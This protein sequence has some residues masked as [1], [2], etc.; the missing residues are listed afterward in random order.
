MITVNNEDD[1][2]SIFNAWIEIPEARKSETSDHF[3]LGLEGNV[4]PS[5]ST[6]FQAYYKTLEGLMLYNQDKIDIYDPDY[7][8]GSGKAHGFEALIRYGTDF[9]DLYAAYTLGWT[10]VTANGTTYSPRYDRRHTVNLLSVIHAAA[11]VD[12][13]LRWSMGSGLPFTETVGFYDRLHLTNA[14]RGSYLGETGTPYVM[15]GARNA[16]RL[17]MF[18]QLDASVAYQFV[19]EAVK[20]S[21]GINI[22]NV[23]DQKNIF[24]VDRKTGQVVTMLPFFPT[25]TLN[26]SF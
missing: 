23:Y 25:A 4:L 7:V 8:I 5:L 9:T 12:V 3:V 11:K 10:T 20:G 22:V 14:L 18:H 17:P 24:Y 2:I 15:L 26:I 19:L 16:K 13:S 1:L 6:N 21:F